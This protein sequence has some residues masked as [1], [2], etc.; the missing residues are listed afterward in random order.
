MV[1]SQSDGE[2]P[3]LPSS[4]GDENPPKR[5]LDRRNEDADSSTISSSSIERDE[6]SD[7]DNDFYS[8][9]DREID[10]A[11]DQQMDD[12]LAETDRQIQEEL[13]TQI[14]DMFEKEMEEYYK[15]EFGQSN[16]V[17]DL[18]DKEQSED[19]ERRI[20]S[21]RQMMD[22]L[23]VEAPTGERIRTNHRNSHR[24]TTVSVEDVNA[25]I[26]KAIQ[27]YENRKT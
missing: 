11:L 18:D 23:R 4:D 22:S 8:S 9:Y 12:L 7:D 16:A 24:S 6:S 2:E 21:L 17:Y 25:S 15:Q 20:S 5:S 1:G 14:N 26:S 27:N 10:R 19:Q 13:D 3:L